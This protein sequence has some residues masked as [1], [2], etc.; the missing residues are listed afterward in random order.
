MKNVRNVIWIMSLFWLGVLLTS[1]DDEKKCF[2]NE[3]SCGLEITN[4]TKNVTYA[5]TRR[6]RERVDNPTQPQSGWQFN[7]RIDVPGNAFGISLNDIVQVRVV[8]PQISCR[9]YEGR[10]R[11]RE[12][13]ESFATNAEEP[14][15][16]S[17]TIQV[18]SSGAS[19]SN[20]DRLRDLLDLEDSEEV[21]MGQT[22]E[23][24]Y[25]YFQ[26]STN[27]RSY[28]L[29]TLAAKCQGEDCGGEAGSNICRGQFRVFF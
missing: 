3:A 19:F 22:D 11:S 20:E 16:G 18:E 21:P 8:D 14:A 29:F 15:A 26:K 2:C 12:D 27:A 10:R 4:L 5:P 25:Y 9:C 28:V 6:F 23:G 17:N 13:C 24:Y 1:C 7:R